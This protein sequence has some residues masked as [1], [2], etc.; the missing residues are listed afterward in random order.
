MSHDISVLGIA[1]LSSYGWSWRWYN[2]ASLIK[3]KKKHIQLHITE[4]PLNPGETYVP[5]YL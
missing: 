5:F 1:G 2:D 3:L 4:K